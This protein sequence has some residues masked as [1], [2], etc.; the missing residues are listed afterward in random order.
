MLFER[1]GKELLA[2]PER[3]GEG[4]VEESRSLAGDCRGAGDI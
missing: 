1:G 4:R 3:R 2:D